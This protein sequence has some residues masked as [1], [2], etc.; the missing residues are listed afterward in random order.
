VFVNHLC[1]AKGEQD[2]E[3]NKAQE[4]FA[5]FVIPSSDSPVA[6]N[7]LEEVFYPVTTPVEFCGERYSRSAV[8]TPGNAGLTPLAVAVCLRVELS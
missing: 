8:R 3:A 1:E 2:G 5:E 7:F 6:F 4:R